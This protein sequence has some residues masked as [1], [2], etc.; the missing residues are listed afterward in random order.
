MRLK[1]VVGVTEELIKP[2]LHL[3]T[4]VLGVT[5]FEE[6]NFS[7]YVAPRAVFSS[8]ERN[9]MEEHRHPVVAENSTSNS[10][11]IRMISQIWYHHS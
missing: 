7:F 6:V 5:S 9:G 3:I 1:D 4:R 11:A 10:T 2:A 8:L